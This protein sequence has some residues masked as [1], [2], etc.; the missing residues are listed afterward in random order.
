M[1]QHSC[2]LLHMM[3]TPASSHGAGHDPLSS[4]IAA[5]LPLRSRCA[6]RASLSGVPVAAPSKKRS[7]LENIMMRFVW[8]VSL[9]E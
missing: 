2:C 3:L 4:P 5:I 6:R 8:F 9:E 7:G 1:P